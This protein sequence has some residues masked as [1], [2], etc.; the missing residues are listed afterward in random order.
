VKGVP[1]TVPKVGFLFTGQGA[2]ETAMASGYYRNFSSF[3]ADITEFDTIARQQGFPSILPLFDGT[4]P[5]EELSAV[6]VQLGTCIIQIALARFWIS[7][8]VKPQYV[9]GHSLGEYAALQIAGILSVSDTIYLCG[10][11]AKLL[12]ETCTAYTH[13]MV[14]VKAK[15]ESLKSLDLFGLEVEIACINGIEDTVLCGPIGDIDLLCEKLSQMGY[16]HQKLG[17][18][19][20][21]H[22]SQVEPILDEL[23]ELASHVEFHKSELTMVSTLLG[24]T[25]TAD[26]IGPRYITR[27]C[28]ETVNFLGAVQTAESEGIISAT[29]ICIEIGAHPILISKVKSIIG[30][31]LRCCAS[32]RRGEDVFKTI[33]DSICAL[34]LA[35]HSINWDEY[36]RDF[37][38]SHKVLCLPRYSWQLSNYWMPYKYSWCLTKGDKPTEHPRGSILTPRKVV[39]LSDSI[40]DVVDQ[41]HDDKKSYIVTES[42]LHD[43][44]LLTVVENHRV[45]GLTMAPSVSPLAP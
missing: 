36:H 44:A 39:R 21:F 5:I 2:Q 11:R 37:K 34:H 4:T 22:S 9:I 31:D 17:V 33:T 43:P 12:E 1:A 16:K 35:G 6:V 38:A 32:L 13:G 45:N 18:P 41:V 28:R 14:A 26:T 27:H 30:Q 40:H 10:H 25:I 23:Q 8:G 19:F 24:K 3:R 15:A 20:A 29:G 42:D 7:L